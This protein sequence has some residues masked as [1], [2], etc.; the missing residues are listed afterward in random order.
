M[1]LRMPH[2]V[3]TKP[4]TPSSALIDVRQ[5]CPE[6][7]LSQPLPPAPGEKDDPGAALSSTDELLEWL[8]Q[9]PTPRSDFKIGTEHEK[10]GFLKDTLAPLPYEGPRGIET[11]LHGMADDKEDVAAHGEWTRIL[12][13]DKIIGLTRNGAS[14]T[15]E[16]G[17]QLELSG[18]PLAS[19]FETCVE[20]GEH[21]ELLRRVCKPLDVG[22]MGLGFHPTAARDDMAKVPKSRYGI[23]RRYMPTKG[24]RGLDMMM[25]TCTI[26]A[27]FD[28]ESEADMVKSFRTALSITPVVTALFASSPFMDGKPSGAL[29]ERTAVWGD[30]DPDRSGFPPVVF[31]DGF[32]FEKWVDYLLDVPMYFIRRDGVHLDYA[33]RSFREFMKTGFDG[34]QA[35]M[36]DW[37]DHLTVAFPEVRV[38]GYMEVRG[39][40]GG[41][42]SRI[43]ALP[44]LW[45]GILYDERSKDAVWAL[46]DNPTS[47]EL[48]KLNQ[49]V[50]QL[51]FKAQYRDKTVLQL[52]E[53]LL[54][55][56]SAGL[57]RLRAPEAKSEAVFLA[58][59]EKAVTSG[60][61]FADDLLRLYRD[62][63]DE[64]VTHLYEHLE[65]SEE[66]K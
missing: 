5:T 32:G 15:L 64:D 57:E 51:G 33:G 31:E 66:R 29:S 19:V 40:D 18:A 43:C 44:A 45:K 50:A 10:F 24:S 14:V 21:L 46:M 25:R 6:L 1:L 49:D 12:E 60:Q 65:F 8:A 4:T 36:R 17:G 61:T 41:P 58:P 13:S 55:L 37:N 42:W 2:S 11:I 54:E 56:S 20:V 34:H 27:N 28:Y 9:S 47:E 3:D 7:L 52:A 63:W 38:K 16:P 30:T 53:Q 48:F 35:T 39:A 59:L 26:Q 62:E 22:F 23:M